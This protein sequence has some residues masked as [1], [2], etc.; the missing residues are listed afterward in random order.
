MGG[1]LS[2]LAAQS[3]EGIAIEAMNPQ[4]NSIIPIINEAGYMADKLQIAVARFTQD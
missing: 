3:L 1:T 2:C 4:L